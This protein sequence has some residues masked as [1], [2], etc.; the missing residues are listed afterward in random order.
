MCRLTVI[1]QFVGDKQLDGFYFFGRNTVVHDLVH[2]RF[3]FSFVKCAALQQNFADCQ[4]FAFADV[5]H[6]LRYQPVAVGSAVK[7]NALN[8]PLPGRLLGKEIPDAVQIALDGFFIDTVGFCRCF[9]F[10]TCP[11]CSA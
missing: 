1:E 10:M 11:F 9:L 7:F 2:Q 8:Q 5:D 6:F 3:Q 4:H